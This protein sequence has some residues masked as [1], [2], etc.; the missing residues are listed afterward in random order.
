MFLPTFKTTV[1]CFFLRLKQLCNG[2]YYVYNN[3]A[4]F[5][6]TF[7]TTV[8]YFLLRLKQLCNVSSYV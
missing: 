5:L 4:M 1:Q 3:C 2:S 8:Q 7:K 6:T